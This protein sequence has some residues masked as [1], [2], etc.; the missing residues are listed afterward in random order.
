MLHTIVI[1]LASRMQAPGLFLPRSQWVWRARSS[2]ISTSSETT[3]CSLIYAPQAEQRF[4]WQFA[5]PPTSERFLS[6]PPKGPLSLLHPPPC[7]SPVFPSHRTSVPEARFTFQQVKQVRKEP[8]PCAQKKKKAFAS[9]SFIP[10]NKT[11]ESFSSRAV[12][13]KW[14]RRWTGRRLFSGLM[15]KGVRC[16]SGPAQDNS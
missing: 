1:Y 5:S 15:E 14:E 4:G 10:I 9:N 3:C 8:V 16:L 12:S 13:G 11:C 6:A 2:Y 7:C